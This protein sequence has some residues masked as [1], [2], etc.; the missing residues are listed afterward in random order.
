MLDEAVETSRVILEAN[1][2]AV[3][4]TLL[5]MQHSSVLPTTV[6][7]NRRTLEDL[8]VRQDLLVLKQSAGISFSRVMRRRQ[9]PRDA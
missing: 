3:M 5:P 7:K 6:I 8:M 4:F 2:N 1:N 9:G